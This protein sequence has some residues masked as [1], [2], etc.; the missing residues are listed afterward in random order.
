MFGDDKVEFAKAIP[1]LV[2]HALARI[3]VVGYRE[4]TVLDEPFVMKAI[5][6]YFSANDPYLKEEIQQL[7][8]LSNSPLGHEITWEYMLMSIFSETFKTR[9]LSEWPHAPPISEMCAALVGKVEIVG[10][11]EPGSERGALSPKHISMEDFMDAHVNRNSIRNNKAVAPF[12]FFPKP[13][14]SGP[15]MVFFI[16]IGER[17][18]PVAVQLKLRQN[19]SKEDRE[20]AVSTVS[21]EK[22]DCH[23]KTFR[24]FCPEKIYVSVIVAYPVKWTSKLAPRPD[25]KF[26]GDDDLQQ[27]VINVEDSNFGKIFAGDHVKF[28]DRLKTLGERSVQD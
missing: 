18:I 20:E 10:W 1:E 25:I 16:R 15:D 7:V 8:Q 23:A 21:V 13:K 3:K 12:I 6:E 9:P 11:K 19:F 5:E 24:D 2:E 4:N 27:V 28:I 26:E 22:T 14:P 17:I